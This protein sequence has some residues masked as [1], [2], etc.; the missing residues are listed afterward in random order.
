M[1]IN[2]KFFL[3]KRSVLW[4]AINITQVII[5][6]ETRKS[7]LASTELDVVWKILFCI[8]LDPCMIYHLFS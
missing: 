5:C 4:L 6:L 1:M 3:K 7:V 8:L 2:H